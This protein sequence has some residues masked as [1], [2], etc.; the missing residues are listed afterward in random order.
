MHDNNEHLFCKTGKLHLQRGRCQWHQRWQSIECAAGASVAWFSSSQGF[1]CIRSRHCCRW[2]RRD[3]SPLE[4][5][6]S[7]RATFRTCSWVGW[8]S[9]LEMHRSW[10]GIHEHYIHSKSP[11]VASWRQLI[12][13]GICIGQESPCE[14]WVHP[15]IAGSYPGSLRPIFSRCSVSPGQDSIQRANVEKV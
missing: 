14:S 5:R 4:L 8:A 13:W 15:A 10:P 2:F 11:A 7:L 9:G 12:T 6:F 1:R 3:R